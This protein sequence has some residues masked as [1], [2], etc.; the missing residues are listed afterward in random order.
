MSSKGSRER[1]TSP[2]NAVFQNQNLS[3]SGVKPTHNEEAI[4]PPVN[5]EHTPART[6]TPIET[7][8]SRHETEEVVDAL[9]QKQIGPY[10]IGKALGEGTF[11]TV[12]LGQHMETKQKVAIKILEKTKIA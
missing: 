12:R 2:D 11:G 3:I 6:I 9:T 8:I 5:T 4:P 1:L 7:A 10:R